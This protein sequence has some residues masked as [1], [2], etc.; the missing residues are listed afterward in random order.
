MFAGDR[1]GRDGEDR[2][3]MV[4]I[5]QTQKSKPQFQGLQGAT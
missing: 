1:Q 4:Q 5:M 2:S 3:G